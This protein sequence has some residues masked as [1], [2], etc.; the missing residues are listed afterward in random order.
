MSSDLE[1]TTVLSTGKVDTSFRLMALPNELLLKVIDC[2]SPEDV[3]SFTQTCKT[4]HGLSEKRLTLHR[5][6]KQEY[7]EIRLGANDDPSYRIP[8]CFFDELVSN[9]DLVFYPTSLTLAQYKPELWPGYEE[10]K[11]ICEAVLQ[12]RDDFR[13]FLSEDRVL[14]LYHDSWWHASRLSH[15]AMP[16]YRLLLSLLPNLRNVIYDGIVMR[17]EMDSILDKILSARGEQRKEMR[18]LKKLRS[19]TTCKFPRRGGGFHLPLDP[20]TPGIWTQFRTLRSLS[21]DLERCIEFPLN[22]DTLNPSR[23]E[24]LELIG[25]TSA[26]EELSIPLSMMPALKSF[27]YE[28]DDVC[29]AFLQ[30]VQN[31]CYQ[32]LETLKLRCRIRSDGQPL[33]SLL[34]FRVLR[35]VSISDVMFMRHARDAVPKLVDILPKTIE[36]ITLLVDCWENGRKMLRGMITRASTELPLLHT[37]R[38]GLNYTQTHVR[39]PKPFKK[40]MMHIAKR[41]KAKVE[42]VDGFL[43]LRLPRFFKE[44]EAE[45]ET[46]S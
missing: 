12:K 28:G 20:H 32:S 15:D 17:C 19:V 24:H 4:I 9:P 1:D 6:L 18:A 5:R 33:D 35:E 27:S 38:V 42:P 11:E 40:T 26:L 21:V 31:E 10:H 46:E 36:V 37:L 23:L 3:E 39:V 2:V 8:I 22:M 41:L 30:P 29:R 34:F 44:T 14:G 16:I 45:D 43:E 7:G 25:C 13:D